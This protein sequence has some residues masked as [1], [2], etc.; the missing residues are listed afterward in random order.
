MERFA[1]PDTDLK[2]DGGDT[3]AN[4]PTACIHYDQRNLQAFKK[5]IDFVR[6]TLEHYWSTMINSVAGSRRL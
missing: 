4:R 6:L 2:S 5:A 3:N 1:G